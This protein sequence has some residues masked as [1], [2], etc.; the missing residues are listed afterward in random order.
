MNHRILTLILLILLAFTASA[1][2][3]PLDPPAF[4]E[5][6]LT[7]DASFLET[8]EVTLFFVSSDG[9]TTSGVSHSFTG[10]EKRSVV[11]AVLNELLT[12]PLNL[13]FRVGSPELALTGLEE[14]NGVVTLDLTAD[15]LT[16]IEAQDRYAFMASVA[17]TLLG[18][19]S[20]RAVNILIGGRATE[21]EGLPTGAFTLSSGS[22]PALFAQLG[23]EGRRAS[24]DPEAA[25]LRN[26]CLY[27]P[28]EDGGLC[29]PCVRTLEF[30]GDES[31][32][33]ET[34]L[35]ALSDETNV[36]EGCRALPACAASAPSIDDNGVRV[37]PLSLDGND[38]DLRAAVL[39]LTTFLPAL[40]A[41]ESNGVRL[42]RRDCTGH[43]AD[44]ADVCFYDP[45]T[46]K[47]ARR[48]VVTT[49][50]RARSALERL[51]L[52]MDATPPEGLAS[53]FPQ[54]VTSADA[55]GLGLIE[56]TAVVDL[57]G[58]FY[59]RCQ[60]LTEDEE[61]RLIYGMIDIL[62]AS[63]NI[64]AVRFTFDGETVE[65]LAGH[66]FTATALLPDPN[67]V[68]EG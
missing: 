49:P 43:I 52:A 47:L 40:D 7:G 27:F 20:V 41:V 46:G 68:G 29:L 61:R 34:I 13:R 51:R 39:T 63:L 17:D 26:V 36:P 66:L 18:I 33:V 21:T 6:R 57:S 14:S 3:F 9:M 48:A 16:G 8:R 4:E 12:S 1:S 50:M 25:Y 10:D 53:I 35:S 5:E 64:D 54:G 60:S 30:R 19:D 15:A 42:A 38:A 32:R 31:S 59:A 67:I 45:G 24:S 62:S 56:Q 23:N 11:E 58:S 44:R 22:I 55:I 37:L 2:S 65:A 28:A